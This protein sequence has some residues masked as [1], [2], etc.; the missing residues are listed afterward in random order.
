MNPISRAGRCIFRTLVFCG[1]GLLVCSVT[2]GAT[3]P[4]GRYDADSRTLVVPVEGKDRYRYVFNKGGAV[5]GIFDLRIAPKTNLIADSF[6]GETTDRV[7]QWTYWNARYLA[8]SH[9]VGNRDRRANA[10]MEGSHKDAATCEVLSAPK[11]GVTRKLVFRSRLQHWF[12]ANLDKHGQPDFETTTLYEVLPEGS[13]QLTRSVLKRPWKMKNLQ[14][15]TWDG[16]AWRQE[17]VAETTL[18]AKHLWHRSMTSY[19]EGWSPFRRSVLPK[20]RHAKGEFKK[21]GYE[22]WKPQDLGGWAMVYG[23]KQA[24]A[25]V[26][27]KREYGNTKGGPRVVFNKIDRPDHG[28]VVLLPAIETD[29]PDHSIITQTLVLVIGSPD[30]VVKRAERLAD[31]VPS[32]TISGGRTK[33]PIK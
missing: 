22:F 33:V 6:Q 29:W 27:G 21:D 18:E 32:P 13:L 17:K 15:K 5:K 23:D 7:I 19:F 14:V 30:E 4:T 26:F 20:Q 8:D 10:T 31:Q 9:E 16:K 28:V 1:L 2:Q 25:I 11:S 3:E 24:V 12:Y